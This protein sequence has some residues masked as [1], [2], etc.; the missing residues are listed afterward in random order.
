MKSNF[1][2]LKNIDKSLYDAIIDA[3]KLF[4]DEYLS[5]CCVQIRIFAEKTAKKIL[6]EENSQDTFD[7]VINCLKDKIK[8][9][10]EKELVEDLFFIKRE[11]N[12]CAH[13]EQTTLS[14]TLETIRRAFEISVNY[15]YMLKKDSKIDK[16]QFDE[17]LLVT[18]KN[19]K[20]ETLVEK[21][22][23]LA[24]AQ[25]E[26]LLNS[27]QGEFDQNINKT[28]DGHKDESYINKPRQYKKKKELTPAQKRVKEKVKEARKNIKQ[29]INKNFEKKKKFNSKKTKT[30][31]QKNGFIKK[32]LFLIFVTISLFFLTK[33]LFF[34]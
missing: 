1:D 25:K 12:K 22:V 17:T 20:E 4:R 33:M 18:G 32:I 13:G 5:Q 29:N 30:K 19:L 9:E 15:A 7:D 2:F 16:L 27:K 21:Y 34:F 6:G 26:E 28:I 3:E 11:G 24:Q 31:R 8:T 10:R 14:L 23:A